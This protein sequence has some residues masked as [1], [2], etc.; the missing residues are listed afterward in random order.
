MPTRPSSTPQSANVFQGIS[1]ENIPAIWPQAEQ[2]IELGL[3]E[4]DTLEQVYS[5][6]LHRENQLWCA[7]EDQ[8]MIAACVT[9]LPTLGKRKVCNVI[10]VGGT[11]M[12][13][14]L[15]IALKTIEAWAKNNGC[16]AMRF[17]EIRKG[18]EKV[19][20]DYRVTKITIEKEL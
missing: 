12:D 4:G 3:G 15:G 17:P 13:G 8:K 19:L 2:L 9:E 14:W 16:D 5:R 18:W 7:F 11:G 1:S 20:K 10:A 6:L